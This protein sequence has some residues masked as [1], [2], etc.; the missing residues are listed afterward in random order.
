M[1]V[2]RTGGHMR[3]RQV[4]EAHEELADDLTAREGE[5]PAEQLDPLVLAQRVVFIEPGG[6]GAMRPTQ[7][8]EPAGIGD[9]GID[10]EAIADDRGIAEEARDVVRAKAGDTIDVP[11]G[12]GGGEG[13]AL[14]QN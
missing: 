14:L 13:F 5:G 7:I 10:L 1:G 3:D 4:A 12:K 9:R 8:D 11:A 2:G 6:E